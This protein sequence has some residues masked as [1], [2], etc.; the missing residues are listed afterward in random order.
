MAKNDYFYAL[1]RRKSAT[2][3]VRLQGGTGAITINSKPA[4][5]YLADSKYLLKELA[6][7]FVV[8]EQTNKYNVSAVVSGGGHS[9]QVEA[10]QLGIAKALALMNEDLKGTLR[11]ADLLG[12]DPREK[13]RK[14][15]GLRGAR[16]QRQFTKR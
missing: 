9:G 5:E 16:K 13:E 10:I 12:R 15:F 4:E 11:R 6:Q 7:P 2:A 14:K 3:R 8:I 1:G